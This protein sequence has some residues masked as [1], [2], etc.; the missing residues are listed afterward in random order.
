MMYRLIALAALLTLLIGCGQTQPTALPAQP[1][2]PTRTPQPSAAETQPTT[3]APG[4]ESQTPAGWTHVDWQGLRIAY[5]PASNPIFRPFTPEPPLRSLARLLPTCPPGVDCP[6]PVT[7]R[8]YPSDGGDAPTWVE[9]N[10]PQGYHDL[11]NVTVD[12]RAGLTYQLGNATDGPGAPRSFYVFSHGTDILEIEFGAGLGAEVIDQLDFDPA[13]ETELAHGQLVY[14]QAAE[15]LDV[16]SA[17]SGGER[18]IEHPKLYHGAQVAIVQLLADAVQ[19]RTMEGS[20]GWLRQPAAQILS[21]EYIAD[22]QI[23]RFVEGSQVTIVHPTGIP[24]RELPNSESGKRSEKLVT[25]T[26]A[27]VYE[28]RGDWLLLHVDGAGDGWARWY[29]DGQIY[30][31]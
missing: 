28:V 18:V 6:F 12:G 26:A 16:W 5:P 7:F 2:A 25:G 29:Y 31:Q 22:E 9:R 24:L 27:V 11:A 30:I 4:A 3:A 20:E 8:I 1:T 23:E 10:H 17:A 13:P 21:R 19:I 14:L 15:A